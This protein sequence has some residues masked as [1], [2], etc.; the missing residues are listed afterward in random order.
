M[1]RKTITKFIEKVLKFP[2]LFWILSILYS[3]MDLVKSLRMQLM[4]FDLIV[5]IFR[6]M[7]PHMKVMET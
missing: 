3:R 6:P 7:P 4:L 2:S 5:T 1:V